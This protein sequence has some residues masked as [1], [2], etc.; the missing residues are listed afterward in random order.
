LL[1]S[2]AACCAQAEGSARESAVEISGEE[3]WKD[4][5][6]E[7]RAGD[8]LILTASGELQ[9]LG[10]KPTGP[11]GMSRGWKDLLRML[12]LNQAGRGALLGR[13][14]DSGQPFLI[15]ERREMTA[16]SGGRLFLG[17]NQASGDTGRGSYAVRIRVAAGDSAVAMPAAARFEPREVAS[18]AGITRKLF[19]KIPRRVQDPDGTPGDMVN[20]LLL[21]DEETVKQALQDAGWVKVD[22]TTKDS[23]LRGAIATLS[24]QAYVELPMSE[25]HLFDRGQDYGFA[26]AEPF[27]VVA[28]RHHF[29]I[30]KAPFQVD[31]QTVWV[32]AGTH[33]IG[34]ERDQRNNKIT[35]KIDPNVDL[36]REFIR[37][38]LAQTGR[39]AE[40]TYLTPRNPIR[41]SKTAHGADY[42]S[43]GRVLV[44]RLPS[45]GLDRA[46]MFSRMFCS[47]LAAQPDAK[48]WG[49]CAQYIEQPQA[50]KLELAPLSTQYRV[51]IVPGVMN[52]CA[53]STPAYQEGQQYLREKYGLTVDL[54]AVPNESAE[55]N[56]WTIADWLSQQ[57]R[58]D[59]R[60]F[61]VFGYSKG[62]PDLHTMLALEPDAV[63]H[64]AAFV[65]VAGAIGGSPIADVMP[66]IADRWMNQM[67][68]GTCRGSMAEAFKSLKREV[69]QAFNRQYPTPRVP[70]YSLAAVADE[71]RVSKMLKQTWQLMSSYDRRQDGQL[72][73]ADATVPG[74]LF[75]GSVLADHFAV[76]LP[77]ANAPEE[78]IRSMV[79]R[80][81]YPRT[82]LLEAMIRFV[83]QDLD[84]RQGKSAAR[85]N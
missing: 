20:F 64:V 35:H 22:R 19:E 45:S 15:G 39:V 7:L 46:Q 57:R 29:R 3:A 18:L 82:A 63:E 52:S 49:D 8:R 65:S 44:M 81:R 17:I 41:K 69:R 59:P 4:S 67:K 50:G 30:W 73:I 32:G 51:L 56:A 38:S 2:A 26:H 70:S 10:E 21:G 62:G 61:I 74:S 25:L 37:E 5:G 58:S 13:I 43:D 76:A 85:S 53:E 72:T 34:F 31:G 79:D 33:D 78:A 84:S 16:G 24:K 36:E 71:S 66:A 80:N 27:V 9:Y 77:L 1:S 47:V 12:P 54:L 42:H 48:E 40:I 68:F 14:G 60:K 55:D 6:L 75:L 23:L 28:R 11:E 83:V